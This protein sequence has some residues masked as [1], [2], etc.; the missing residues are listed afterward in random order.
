M[1]RPCSAPSFEIRARWTFI[2][3]YQVYLDILSIVRFLAAF[4]TGIDLS[5]GLSKGSVERIWRSRCHR[6]G[7]G[8]GCDAHRVGDLPGARGRGGFKAVFDAAWDLASRLEIVVFPGRK[9]MNMGSKGSLKS[10]NGRIWGLG[11]SRQATSEHVDV[12]D[13]GSGD[14]RYLRQGLDCDARGFSLLDSHCESC[15]HRF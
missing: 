14:G 15:L 6:G 13:F 7:G 3:L 4:P 12:L 10:R 8:K 9:R 2:E 5:I 1:P 11:H